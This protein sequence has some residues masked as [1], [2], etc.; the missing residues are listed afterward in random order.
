MVKYRQRK[1]ASTPITMDLTSSKSPIGEAWESLPNVYGLDDMFDSSP[2]S[3][4]LTIDQEYHNFAVAV[5]SPKGTNLVKFWEVRNQLLTLSCFR[6]INVI[7]DAREF[8]T[9]DL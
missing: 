3:D 8:S 1:A 5:I 6:V 2:T 9:N 7:T 4:D